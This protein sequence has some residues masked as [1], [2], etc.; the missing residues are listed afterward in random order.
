MSAPPLPLVR[1]LVGVLAGAARSA[2]R[3]VDS[4]VFRREL[5]PSDAM[6]LFGVVRRGR[7]P[8]KGVFSHGDRLQVCRTDARSYTAQ[9]VEREPILDGTELL[10]PRPAMGN[11]RAPLSGLEESVPIPP[12]PGEPNPALTEVRPIVGEGAVFIDLLPEPFSLRLLL[13]QEWVARAL[14]PHVVHHAERARVHRPA[15]S[16]DGANVLTQHQNLCSTS[17]RDYR[18]EE[19]S[20]NRG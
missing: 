4:R 2:A 10:F 1:L 5:V 15:A 8:T 19:W 9:V 13:A 7:P 14:D 18:I 17:S 11:R 6:R 12:R 3:L 20:V 16:L